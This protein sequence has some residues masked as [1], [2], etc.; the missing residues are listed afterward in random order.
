MAATSGSEG[1]VFGPADGIVLDCDTRPVVDGGGGMGIAAPTD[2]HEGN[3]SRSK[4]WCGNR[5]RAYFHPA[6]TARLDLNLQADK[7][8]QVVAAGP[9]NAWVRETA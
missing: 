7:A 9:S 1:V 8:I 4:A 3:S 2:P 6:I 5:C